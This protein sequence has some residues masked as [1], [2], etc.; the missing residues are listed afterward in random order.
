[1]FPN[2]AAHWPQRAQLVGTFIGESGNGAGT[3]V[4]LTKP[5]GVQDGDILVAF[6]WNSVSN[7]VNNFSGFTHKS[8]LTVTAGGSTR[9]IECWTRIS[10]SDGASYT[11]NMTTTSGIKIVALLAYRPAHATQLDVVASQSIVTGSGTSHVASSITPVT[12]ETTMLYAF[13][14]SGSNI[15]PSP[16]AG[17]ITRVWYQNQT[18]LNSHRIFV[19]EETRFPATASGTRTVTT[20]S[21]V[22]SACI[23]ALIKKK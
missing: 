11:V 20:N 8:S 13:G 3:G 19:C 14:F 21:A 18:G 4:V 10:A 9:R 22:G 6:V 5:T 7:N 2:V 23:R 17:M 16:P 1:M 15:E 12:R